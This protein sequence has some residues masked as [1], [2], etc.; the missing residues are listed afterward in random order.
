LVA[1]VVAAR[2]L[3]YSATHTALRCRIAGELVATVFSP[4]QSPIRAPEFVTSPTTLL[5]GIA[6]DHRVVFNFDPR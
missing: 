3:Q 1:R 4:Y 6:T 5:R 2:F